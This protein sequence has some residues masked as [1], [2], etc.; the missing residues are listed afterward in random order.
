MF[1][2][3]YEGCAG[4]W[5]FPFAEKLDSTWKPHT[6]IRAPRLVE[7]SDN[8]LTNWIEDEYDQLPLE[9]TKEVDY[10]VKEILKNSEN[11]IPEF[12]LEAICGRCGCDWYE[13]LDKWLKL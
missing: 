2:V 13:E 1:L 12:A 5:N 6:P 3:D 4:S 10:T 7:F 11:G 8:D 9:L